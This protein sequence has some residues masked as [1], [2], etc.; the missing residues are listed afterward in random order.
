MYTTETKFY[1]GNLNTSA[2]GVSYAVWPTR[3][4]KYM[5]GNQQVFRCPAMSRDFDWT[6]NS[7][8]PPVAGPA[9]EGCGYNPGE[10]LLVQ[11][12]AKFSYGYNDWGAWQDPPPSLTI[13]G[14]GLPLPTDR[15]HGLGGDINTT[16]GKEL[17]ASRVL[18]PAEM[19][20]IT[21]IKVPFGAS[22]CFNVD[23]N[24]PSEAPSDIHKGGANVL[25]CDGHATWKHQKDLVLYSLT[26]TNI[27]FPKNTPPW[28]LNAPQWDNQRLPTR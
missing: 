18:H 25:W 6:V 11:N 26:N 9:D 22:F 12:V 8:T 15:Q 17:K 14:D 28:N 20:A 7:T 13:Y 2:A 19:I 16:Y 27:H 3:L 23:P 1:P 10:S 21:D 4:R 5:K 24:N